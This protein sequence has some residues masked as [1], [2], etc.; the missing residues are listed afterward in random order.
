MTPFVC[1]FHR[2]CLQNQAILAVATVAHHF[3]TRTILWTGSFVTGTI[4]F[5]NR[6]GLLHGVAADTLLRDI[7][8]RLPCHRRK[9]RKNTRLIP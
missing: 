1:I 5:H 4:F 7:R 3:E 8:I 9:V 6:D 2:G